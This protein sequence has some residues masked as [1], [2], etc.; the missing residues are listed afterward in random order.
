MKVDFDSEANAVSI[1]LLD[2]DRW[3]DGGEFDEN[4]CTIAFSK[5]RVANIGLLQP[6]ENLHLLEAVAERYH[7]D[8]DRLIAAVKA[9]LAAPDHTVTISDSLAA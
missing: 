5:G 6:T 7:L 2:V 8:P 4:Y 3:D 9:A 1:D